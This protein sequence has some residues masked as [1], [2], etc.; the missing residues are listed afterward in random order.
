M[1]VPTAARPIDERWRVTDSV[2]EF[3][4]VWKVFGARAAEAMAAIRKD[5]LSK[6]E[7]LQRFGCVVAE[8]HGLNRK[9]RLF[10]QSI[11]ML[12]EHFGIVHI[13]GNNYSQY[14]PTNDFPNTVEI[15][16]VNTALL[17][18]ETALSRREYPRAELDRPNHPGRPDHPL[19]FD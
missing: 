9:A 10:N 8:F 3:D 5:A 7:V 13:H 14:D 15:T 11:A 18:G 6:P 16:F 12:R 2:I 4:G 17:P 19:R 1:L